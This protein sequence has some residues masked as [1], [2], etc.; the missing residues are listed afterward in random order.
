MSYVKVVVVGDGGVG[1]TCL[2]ISYTHN[3]FPVEDVPTIFDG[4]AATW[5]VDGKPVRVILW[6]TNGMETANMI[7]NTTVVLLFS[8][9][10][11]DDYDLLRP[12]EYPQTDVFLI[13]FSLVSPDSYLNVKDKVSY[14]LLM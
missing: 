14:I 3:I 13:C 9:I 8:H 11:Q 12:L 7:I 2:L 6:D 4:Y 5:M 10:G 1:K